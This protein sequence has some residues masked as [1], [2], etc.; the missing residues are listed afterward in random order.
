MVKDSR[1]GAQPGLLVRGKGACATEFADLA[2][3]GGSRRQ[4]GGNGVEIC[5][6]MKE[7]A[8]KGRRR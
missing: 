8:C 2:G 4:G 1:Q 5:V 3:G 6:G 7:A